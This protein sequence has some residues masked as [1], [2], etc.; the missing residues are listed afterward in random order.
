[1]KRWLI[2]LVLLVALGSS[3]V[4]AQAQEQS[5]PPQGGGGT[6]QGGG[7]MMQ[8]GGMGGGMMGGGMGRGIMHGHGGGPCLG[9]IVACASMVMPQLAATSD[10][11]VVVAVGGKLV[12]YD[13]GLR[14][15]AETNIN[16]DWTQV[17]QRVEQIMQ[18]CPMH[19]RMMM[20]QQGQFR[21]P[22]Q[23]RFQGQPQGPSQGQ[24]QGQFQSQPQ[25]QFQ[26]QQ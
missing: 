4:F 20:Q 12:K 14:R 1:M 7:G 19:R 23:R 16:I 10:G 18:N 6:M 17:Q 9:C 24:P 25:S 13:A 5:Y 8:G 15:V 26:G 22:P 21:G 3:V 11:G 2:A